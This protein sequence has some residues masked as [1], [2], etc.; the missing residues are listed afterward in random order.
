[1]KRQ[2]VK[3]DEEKCTG[4]GQCIPNCH[5]GALQIIDNKARLISDLFCDGLGAC[6]GHCPEG[7]MTIEEREAEPYDENK[8]MDII[9][10]QGENTIIAHLN[11]LKDHGEVG[12]YNEALKYLKDH[13]INIKTEKQM[14][15]HHH[16]HGHSCP[17]SREMNLNVSETVSPAGDVPSQLRQWPVQLHLLNPAAGYFKNAD[18]LLAADCTAFAVGNFHNDFM[19][20][21]TLAI[22]CP[23]LDSGLD[24]YTEKIT[25]MIDTAQINTLTVAIMEVPCC[26]GLVQIAKTAVANANRKVPIK[27]I[28]V[29]IQGGI[30]QEQWI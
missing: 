9:V 22:A 4:C 2:I 19:K 14:E 23:K 10:T 28:V 7:A 15:S 1:M 26:G 20:G 18:V 27:V 21:K 3:I 25:A 30:Q 6:I 17:G 13:N 11:H 8:V 5:E 12:Y 29:G 24:T 16:H